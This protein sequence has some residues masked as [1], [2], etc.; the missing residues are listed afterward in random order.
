[1]AKNINDNYSSAFIKQFVPKDEIKKE[2][3]NKYHYTSPDAFLS[4]IKNDTLRFTDIRFLNDRSEGMYL[5]KL[6]CDYFKE[7]PQKYPRTEDVFNNLI[8][9]NSYKDIQDLSIAK[10]LMS[11]LHQISE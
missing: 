6:M 8:G 10:S 2:I 1:M 5:V 11:S 7:H 9:E 3:G 4:I